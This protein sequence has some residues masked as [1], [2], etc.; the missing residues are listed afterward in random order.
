VGKRM[1]PHHTSSGKA[2]LA[3]LPGEQ[4][5]KIVESVG[6]PKFTRNTITSLGALK[7]ELAE[8]RQRGYATDDEETAVGIRGA[9]API[10]DSNGNV[11]AS[12]A[13]GGP[14]FDFD[15]KMKRVIFKVKTTAEMISERLGY[16]QVRG[17]PRGDR[18]RGGKVSETGADCFT[19]GDNANLK[20]RRRAMG[21]DEENDERAL[22]RRHFLWKVAGLSPTAAAALGAANAFTGPPSRVSKAPGHPGAPVDVQITQAACGAYSRDD[23]SSGAINAAIWQTNTSDPGMRVE[24]ERG[25]LCIRGTCAKIPDA[26]L[27]TNG[28]KFAHDIRVQSHPIAV[29]DADVAVRVKMPSGIAPD[30][31]AHTVNVHLCGIQPDCYSEVVFGKL[32]SKPMVEWGR[33]YLHI[34]RLYQ[35]ARGWWFAIVDQDP[36]RYWWRVSGDPLPQLGDERENFHDVLVTYDEPTRLSRG[37]LKTG[38]RWVQLGEAERVIRGLSRVELKIIDCTP[39]GGN[40]REARFADYR[41]YPNPKRNP[42]RFVVRN[43][44]EPYRGRRLRI[45]LYTRDH[46]HRVS[47]ANTDED[48]IAHLS[49]D[50]PAW[51]A[52][53]V[54]AAI[55]IFGGEREVARGA[56]D[57]R[58]IYGLYPGDVW[59]LDWS[60]VSA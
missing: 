52:F 18:G 30:P 57:A 23:F 12:V 33:E 58:G 9:G 6:L 8:V 27:R 51:L 17:S 7:K 40:Y 36:G 13:V 53:P 26:E 47:E 22:T 16:S 50:T 45:G 14:V 59:E 5:K 11:V 38:E 35:D 24:I 55:S 4:V 29:V 1:H 20:P 54:S 34:Q 19:Q 48:G 37:Y 39:L 60:Q 21:G 31:G 49:V 44:T 42:A 28:G 2:I 43:D 15:P 56:V 41:F 25:E 32:E 3:Y 10:F 46:T